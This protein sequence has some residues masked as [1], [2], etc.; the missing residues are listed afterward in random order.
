MIASA[1]SARSNA[2]SS[3]ICCS[4]VIALRV[5][6]ADMKDAPDGCSST[7]RNES[8]CSKASSVGS[9]NGGWSRVGQQFALTGPGAYDRTLYGTITLGASIIDCCSAQQNQRL[10]PLLRQSSADS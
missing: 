10:P 8:Q 4:S 7:G 9:C 1:F 6:M 5:S 3:S 2:S